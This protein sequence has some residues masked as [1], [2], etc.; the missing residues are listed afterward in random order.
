MWCVLLAVALTAPA[1][2]DV[3]SNSL[4]SGVPDYHPN[5]YGCAP[6]SGGMIIGYWDHFTDYSGLVNGDIS[7]FTTTAQ[8]MVASQA[9]LSAGRTW[10]G[11]LFLPVSPISCTRSAM[12]R[13]LPTNLSGW[14]TTRSGITQPSRVPTRRTRPSTFPYADLNFGMLASEIDAQ[15]PMLF[16]VYATG[17][18]HAVVAYGYRQYSDGTAYY[19]VRDTWGQWP[20]LVTVGGPSSRTTSNGGPGG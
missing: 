11:P 16:N 2:A 12:T 20:E 3:V 7:T 6:M 17:Q 15:R 13:G 5:S 9:F 18:G 8:R 4:L 10:A 1:S 14:L 19:A